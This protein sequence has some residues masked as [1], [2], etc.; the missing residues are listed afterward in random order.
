MDIKTSTIKFK[1]ERIREIINSS[2]EKEIGE[3]L[4]RRKENRHIGVRYKT[5]KRRC[6]RREGKIRRSVRYYGLQFVLQARRL[7]VQKPK[8]RQNRSQK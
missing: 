6:E 2:G 1:S 3:I 7:Y 5:S 4:R 8:R